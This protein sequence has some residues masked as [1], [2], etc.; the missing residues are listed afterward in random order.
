MK[1]RVSE[2]RR[3]TNLLFDHLEASG[4]DEITVESGYY[5]NIPT[6]ALYAVYEEPSD[7]TMGQLSDDLN[8]VRH[9][10][11]GTKPPIAHALVWVSALLR[12]VGEKVVA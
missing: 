12:Y 4:Q 11:T 3:A 7:F 6:E 2:L 5:W 8:E 10:L 9:L 1:V